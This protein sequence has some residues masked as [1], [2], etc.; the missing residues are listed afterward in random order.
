MQKNAK[1][2]DNLGLSKSTETAQVSNLNPV[3]I[4]NTNIDP[5][6]LLM[7]VTHQHEVDFID[8]NTNKMSFYDINSA[9][10]GISFKLSYGLW[11]LAKS[12]SPTNAT[13]DAPLT[14]APNQLK[15]FILALKG[16]DS[17]QKNPYY[18]LMS[19]GDTTDFQASIETPANFSFYWFNIKN[20][21]RVEVLR[22]YAANITIN[23][24]GTSKTV[25]NLKSPIWSTLEPTDL[26]PTLPGQ[27]TKLLCRLVPYEN[28]PIGIKRYEE[29]E[30]PIYNDHFFI[31]LGVVASTQIGGAQETSEV[32]RTSTPT[33]QDLQDANM[34]T[35]QLTTARSNSPGGS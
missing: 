27:S 31:D 18:S 20:L 10:G 17:V 16:S 1:L 9:A 22:G 13:K 7:T 19:A 29:L 25:T 34:R 3:N 12:Q 6:L 30:M 24:G 35:G 14:S 4:D 8:D 23:Q 11:Y 15:S 32:L 5:N 33:L 26:T 2:S 28:Q 21:V